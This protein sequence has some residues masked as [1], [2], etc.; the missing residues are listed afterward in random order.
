MGLLLLIGLLIVGFG[1]NKTLYLPNRVSVFDNNIF[2]FLGNLARD[3]DE[4]RQ[5]QT[6]RDSDVQI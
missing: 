2:Y 6:D 3:E 4:I 5:I 1:V